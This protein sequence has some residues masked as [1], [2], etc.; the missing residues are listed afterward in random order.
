MNAPEAEILDRGVLDELV[1]SVSGDRAFVVHLVETFLADSAGQIDAVE[2]A[3]QA[4]DAAGLVRPA[5]TLKSSSATVGAMRLASRAR[6]LEVA[7][8]S[9]GID[10]EAR[11]VASMLRA[12]WETAAAALRAWTGEE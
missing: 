4:D 11:S 12:D 8:R 6:M 10:D 1:A 3:V 5:H 9:G 2:A 7:G